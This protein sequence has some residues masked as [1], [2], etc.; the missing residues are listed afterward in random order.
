MDQ[1]SGLTL[2]AGASPLYLSLGP[3]STDR[4]SADVWTTPQRLEGT[5]R[6]AWAHPII[7]PLFSGVKVLA[8]A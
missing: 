8:G 2:V 7:A 6:T 4:W 3:H 5:A 1:R